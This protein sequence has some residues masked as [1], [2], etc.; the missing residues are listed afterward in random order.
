MVKSGTANW[1]VHAGGVGSMWSSQ[2][3]S[4]TM[5]PAAL[6]CPTGLVGLY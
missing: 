3:P 6:T 2:R 5:N 1:L 4:R